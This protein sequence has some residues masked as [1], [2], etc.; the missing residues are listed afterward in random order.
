M[1]LVRF[2]LYFF[3][4]S[5]IYTSKTKQKAEKMNVNTDNQ[6]SMSQI[7]PAVTPPLTNLF[8]FE[9]RFGLI[10]VSIFDSPFLLFS[11]IW[12]FKVESSV[13]VKKKGGIISKR[14]ISC[15]MKIL[16]LF[17]LITL[18]F[19]FGRCPLYLNCNPFVPALTPT[20]DL[21]AYE[22]MFKI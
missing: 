11:P 3:E 6:K 2:N 10:Q 9:F 13:C 4:K 16:N 22:L 14:V 15:R 7:E 1:F 21:E 18:S 17:K 5:L 8:N 19:L 12:R 20:S